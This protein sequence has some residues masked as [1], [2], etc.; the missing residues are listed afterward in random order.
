MSNPKIELL[1]AM[2]KKAH[3]ETL[4]AAARVPEQNR[5]LHLQE[6]K[7]TPLWLMGHLA[8]TVNTIVL[9]WTLEQ[10]GYFDRDLSRVFSPDF[11]KGTPP[12]TD[13]SL[14]PSWDEVV[15]L[16]DTVMTTA[17]AGME[18]LSDD[19]LPKPLPGKML[20]AMRAFFS[21]IEVALCQMVHHDAYHRGQIGMLAKLDS[22]R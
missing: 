18:Q 19:D 12:S 16:Y 1:T 2:L 7:A 3:T 20:D 11:A 22:P 5:M 9:R 21:S 13:A 8:N 15:A 14:Y 17:I 4:A 10:E 6:G